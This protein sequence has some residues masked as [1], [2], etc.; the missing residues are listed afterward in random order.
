[1]LLKK[2][3][4]LEK[5]I[6]IFLGKIQSIN[7]VCFEAIQEYL[8]GDQDH[9]LKHVDTC[10]ELETE[11]DDIRIEIE[12]NLYGDMLI[13]E[14]R[15]DVLGILETLDDVADTAKEIAV[16]LDVEKPE[17]TPDIIEPYL[18]MARMSRDSVDELIKAV[19]TFFTHSDLTGGFIKKVNFFEHEIDLLEEE[20]KRQVF[21]N[22]E[23]ERLSHKMHLRF[24]IEKL[25]QLSDDAESVCQR[26]AL[27]TIKR[28]I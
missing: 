25:A 28:S 26:L 2:T 16:C 20:L 24:F 15:G 18:K 6:E 22:P 9:F 11:I 21:A 12:H 3:K 8:K 7:L 1:M 5:D 13:P 14:S 10:R 19:T 23:I 17:F 27:S 4:I